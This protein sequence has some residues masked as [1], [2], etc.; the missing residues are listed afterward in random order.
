MGDI[1]SDTQSLAGV[2]DTAGVQTGTLRFNSVN[3][4]GHQYQAL[5]AG[6]ESSQQRRWHTAVDV[7]DAQVDDGT[8]K[9]NL[10]DPPVNGMPSPVEDNAAWDDGK[11]NASWDFQSSV[12][13]RTSTGSNGMFAT[14][15]GAGDYA[16]LM[17]SYQKQGGL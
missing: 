5:P 17:S 13:Q 10:V 6:D 9:N 15:N 14:D 12:S 7:A 3:V 16:A 8:D 11:I 1:L 2:S 4:D